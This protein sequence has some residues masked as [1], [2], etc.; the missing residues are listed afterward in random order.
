MKPLLLRLHRWTTLIFALPLALVI[1][2]GLILSLDPILQDAGARGVTLSGADLV[3]VLDKHD[4][5]AKARG[6]SI[7]AYENRMTLQGVGEDGSLDLDLATKAEVDDSERTMLSEIIGEA[8][9]LHE[10][11]LF[12]LGWVVTASTIAMVVL[13]ILG[14]LMGWPRIRNSFSG[15]HQGIA[16]VLLPI[17]A[18]SP[19]TGLMLAFRI[20]LSS[21]PPQDKSAPLPLKAAVE[22][23]GKDRDLGGLIW[24]RTRGGRMLVRINEGGAFNVYQVSR[25]GVTPMSGNWPRA[26]HEGNAYGLWTGIMVLVTSL[27]FVGLMV[28]GLTIWFRRTFLRKRNRDRG[29]A[30]APAGNPA[31]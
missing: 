17:L 22:M 25:N 18:L 9:G 10:H 14:V 31:E 8:R 23:L 11:F 4:P 19:I 5:D 16:W 13:I 21:L 1:V 3:S 12:D 26:L 24:L 27:A 6:I 2:T 28:T 30:S 29:G 20:S 15:W 7:R